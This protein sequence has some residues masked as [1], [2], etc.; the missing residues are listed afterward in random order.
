MGCAR[1]LARKPET[2]II[3]TAYGAGL[4]VSKSRVARDYALAAGVEL[5]DDSS[6]VAEW[7]TTA[8]GGFRARGVGGPVT[9][10]P[11]KLL[12]VDDPHKDRVDAESAL[13]RQRVYD[14][15]TSTASTRL[16]PGSSVIV[17]HTRWHSDD[18]IGRLAAEGGWEVINLP[19]LGRWVD[20]QFIPDN[21]GEPLWNARP[22][23]FFDAA[24]K[25][26]YDW[27]ALY[28]GSP[29]P[30][31]GGLFRGIKHYDE[32][33]TRYRVGKGVDLAYTSKTRADYSSGVVM[34]ESDGYYYVAEVQR[35]QC[36]V[37]QFVSQLKASNARYRLGSWH[38]FCSTTERG[39]AQM[40]TDSGLDVNGQLAT[41]DKFVRAQAF[42]AAWNEGRVLLPRDAPWLRAY[43]DELM[44]FTGVSD[45]HDDQV[46]A[47]VSAFEEFR[48]GSAGPARSVTGSGYRFSGDDR[49]FG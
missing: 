11:A 29:R 49:G 14:W 42:A 36:E 27:W 31:G 9:G 33:P 5:R 48:H 21:D 17:C 18:L 32:L 3:Y 7:L 20:G 15:F 45:K 16:H 40:L 37:P 28:M 13:M 24:K 38:W 19:A 26:E 8:G 43:A 30:K 2:P 25:H 39:L 22:K 12:I 1:L 10:N 34:L 4:A 35:A 41:A 44:A 47:S 23:S 6:S 46:D